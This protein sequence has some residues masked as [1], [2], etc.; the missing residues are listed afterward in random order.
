MTEPPL[1]QG[2]TDTDTD[3]FARYG[4]ALVPRREEQIATVCDLLGDLP[5]PY[6]LDLCC[7]EG[8]LSQ[9][10]LR[11]SPEARVMLMDGSA[12]MLSRAGHRLVLRVVLR[13]GELRAVV[14]LLL[15]IAPE[16]RLARLE[17]AD[18]R[19]AGGGGVRAGVLGR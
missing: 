5:V 14:E 4:D 17:A 18:Q 2:W 9:E 10:Y 19:M 15:R 1:A 12:E 8:R 16:P 7:G 6:V 13:R 11:R 3:A